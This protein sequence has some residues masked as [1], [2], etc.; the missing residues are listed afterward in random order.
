MNSVRASNMAGLEKVPSAKLDD[1]S[2]LSGT[3]MVQG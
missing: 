1:L 3:R 2:F